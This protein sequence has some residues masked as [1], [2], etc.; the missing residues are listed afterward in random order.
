[1]TEE[2]LKEKGFA[3]VLYK[4]YSIDELFTV[5]ESCANQKQTNRIDLSPLLA[6][7]EKQHTLEKLAATT[8]TDMAGVR[9]AAETQNMEALDIWIHHLRSSWM[10][11][12]AE[13]PLV[14]LYN[15]IHKE[16]ISDEE[17][18][19]AVDRVLAQGYLIIDLARKEVKR[20]VE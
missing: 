15:I 13:Q 5:T 11:I 10:L 8:Q 6:F 4:P 19:I 18:S 7:G 14:S 12:K 1:M 3:S 2:E 17:L 20:W 16:S 9:Q